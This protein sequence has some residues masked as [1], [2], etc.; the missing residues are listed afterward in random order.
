MAHPMVAMP[1][2]RDTGINTEK[3]QKPAS[4]LMLPLFLSCSVAALVAGTHWAQRW[5]VSGSAIESL[6]IL[7]GA[8]K[9][10]R[11]FP[12]VPLWALLATGNLVY[13]I[14]STSWLL[15]GLFAAVCY[16][17]IG[18]T[19]LVQFDTAA[20]FARKNLRKILKQ[21]HFTRDR[22][23]LFSLPAL[24]ID[25]NVNGLM[26]VRGV[27]ILLSKLTIVAH[28]VE[29]GMKLI[30]DVELAMYVDEVTIPL[31]RRIQIGDIYGS[32]K[33]GKAE[34][35]FGEVDDRG[36]T[37]DDDFSMMGDTALLRAATVGAEGFSDQNRPNLRR[38]QMGV[39][40]MEDSSAMGGFD[41]V[42]T[43]SPDDD[44]AEKQY[45]AILDD[46]RT[47]STVYQSRQQV[48]KQM[49]SDSEGEH[50]AAEHSDN[51][52]RAAI[53]AEL[54][55]QP[56][57]AHPPPRSVRVT[58]LQNS[59]PP[60]VRRFMHRLPFLL[61]F[62]LAVL[63]YF[64]LININSITIAGSGR[65]AAAM[66]EKE[67]FK[68][69]SL[70]NAELRRLEKRVKAWL[71]DANFCLSLVD[72][73]GMV[74]V[75]LRVAWDI[76]GF[77]NFKDLM[78]YRTAPEKVGVAQVVRLGGADATA[79]IPSFLLPHHEHVVPPA[80]NPADEEELEET[81]RDADG[82]PTTKQAEE[83]AAKLAKD[84]A[85]IS[86]SVHAS[87]PATFDQSLL[88][89]VAALV[90][91]TKIIEL[92]KEFEEVERSVAST[93]S[94]VSPTN[95]AEDEA[96]TRTSTHDSA[97]TP[98]SATSTASGGEKNA[99][100]KELTKNLRQNLEDGT[101]GQQIKDLAKD[102]SLSTNK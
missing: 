19:C 69:Y 49:K 97:T 65:F 96:L 83:K 46:I 74:Q 88:D 30:D 93:A 24:E 17:M 12:D 35:F 26:V 13:A 78:A 1:R 60:Y 54:R 44:K 71:A 76:V 57:I 42:K 66:L 102:I 45:M 18:I 90:K 5:L 82:L 47:T 48:L 41:F 40:W 95:S 50:E 101:T 89:F 81:V 64:H 53:C 4:G 11:I 92:E 86:I 20:T 6:L 16:P 68:Q 2:R 37:M 67:V 14:C 72:V 77:L 3:R 7:Y 27:T 59:S 84:E 73:H 56:S 85:A 98:I 8:G 9:G 43:L 22:I 62:L 79:T 38:S 29:L 55:Q 15:Y 25:T 75:P 70:E 33:G 34:L 63:S 21:L 23:A 28:G 31:F 80:P 61:R 100:F 52:M 10:A 94:P 51:D 36:D 32:L 87:L 91:A 99:R 39:S 58:T